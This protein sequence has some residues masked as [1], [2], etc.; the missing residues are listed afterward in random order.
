MQVTITFTPHPEAQDPADDTG[1]TEAAFDEVM[2]ALMGIGDDI[3][4]Q[5]S[6]DL[7]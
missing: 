7:A 5:K 3:K 4:I 1:L 2:D 6:T